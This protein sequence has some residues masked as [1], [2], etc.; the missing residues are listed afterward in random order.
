MVLEEID[1]VLAQAYHQVLTALLHA[2]A[3][4]I[5]LVLEYFALPHLL[6]TA[7]SPLLRLMGLVFLFKIQVTGRNKGRVL[8]VY[9]YPLILPILVDND[10]RGMIQRRSVGMKS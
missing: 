8:Y 6:K 4:P 1:S 5:V 9:M 10:K 3:T 7:A 2:M